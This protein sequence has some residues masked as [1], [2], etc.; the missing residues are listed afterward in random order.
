MKSSAVLDSLSAEL[1]CVRFVLFKWAAFTMLPKIHTISKICAL[2]YLFLSGPNVLAGILEPGC[3]GYD[4]LKE[5][6]DFDDGAY[7]WEDTGRR[8]QVAAR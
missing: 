7:S 6:V 4:C 5:Y 8:I 2:L 3:I 1:D